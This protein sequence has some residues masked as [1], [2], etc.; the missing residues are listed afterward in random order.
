MV[1]KR[2][3]QDLAVLKAMQQQMHDDLIELKNDQKKDRDCLKEALDQNTQVTVEMRIEQGKIIQWQTMHEK[4]HEHAL[5][6]TRNESIIGSVATGFITAFVTLIA[7][8]KKW[9]L[10]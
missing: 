10:I 8:M 3:A 4:E 2:E 1:T 9:G 7:M 6:K 5:R